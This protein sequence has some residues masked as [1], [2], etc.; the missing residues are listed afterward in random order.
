MGRH[1]FRK[2]HMSQAEHNPA[3]EDCYERGTETVI[4]ILKVIEASPFF[5]IRVF[6]ANPH[7]S[8]PSIMS[9][10]RLLEMNKFVP[11]PREP[12]FELL[13]CW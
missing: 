4:N 6:P 2:E 5:V 11:L 1:G 3:E 13:R 10:P 8:D 12:E 7:Q 9:R